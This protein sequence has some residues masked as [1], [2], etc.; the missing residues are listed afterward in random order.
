MKFRQLPAASTELHHAMAWYRERSPRAAENFWLRVMEARRSIALF[1]LATP[2]VSLHC[3]RFILSGYP[4]DLI[5]S[6]REDEILIVA[7]AHH[8]R[9]PGYWQSRLSKT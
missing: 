2:R 6:L 7:F 4:Y 5:Y 3:R 1:P 8:S 9:R